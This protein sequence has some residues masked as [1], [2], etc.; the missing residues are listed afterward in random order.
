[1]LFDQRFTETHQIHMFIVFSLKNQ[2]S[3][4][5]L[6]VNILYGNFGLK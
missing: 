2:V 6:T 1:M 4:F 5:I 3:D